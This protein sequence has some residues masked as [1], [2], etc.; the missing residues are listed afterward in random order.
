MK[1]YKS[2]SN[3][4]GAVQIASK[5]HFESSYRKLKHLQGNRLLVLCSPFMRREISMLNHF[6]IC[7]ACNLC[8]LIVD[9]DDIKDDITKEES[10]HK[11]QFIC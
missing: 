2:L 8:R 6:A 11:Y 5:I 1:N 10:R 9:C 3:G 4:C 7:A